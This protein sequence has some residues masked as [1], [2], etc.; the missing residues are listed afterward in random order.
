MMESGL[1]SIY[2]PC[3]NS[4]INRAKSY[5]LAAL[6]RKNDFEVAR[7]AGDGPKK[8]LAGAHIPNL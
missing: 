7:K 8:T 2:I 4:A 6:R 3:L 1:S 5:Y